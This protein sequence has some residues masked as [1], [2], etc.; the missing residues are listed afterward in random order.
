MKTKNGLKQKLMGISFFAFIVFFAG[1]LQAQDGILKGDT[2]ARFGVKGGVNFSQLFVD[3][4]D[5]EDQS[6]KVGI[7]GGLWAKVPMGEFFALQPELLYTNNGSR[8]A[9]RTSN[10]IGIQGREVRY[11]LNYIQ[12]PLLASAT[13]GPISLHAGPYASYLIGANIKDL[14]VDNAVNP[15]LVAELNEKDFHR[16]DYGLAGGIAID[17]KGFQLGGRYNF[18]LREISNSGLSSQ[19]TNNAKNSVAQIY[20]AVGF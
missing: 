19:L 6:M 15:T 14:E 5:V 3:N 11:N 13:L 4:I 9:Y 20:I 8:V 1:N 2:Q 16:V 18:G 12:L 17:I 10:A 7:H